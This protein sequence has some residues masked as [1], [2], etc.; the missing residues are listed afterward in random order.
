ML[1]REDEPL[2]RYKAAQGDPDAQEVVAQWD[3]EDGAQEVPFYMHDGSEVKSINDIASIMGIDPLAAAYYVME[4]KDAPADLL[5]EAKSVR[6]VRTPAGAAWYDQPIGSV[7]VRDPPITRLRRLIDR[8]GGTINPAPKMGK[9]TEIP[10]KDG[11]TLRYWKV[12]A[13]NDPRTILYNVELGSL[14]RGRLHELAVIIPTRADENVVSVMHEIQ[15]NYIQSK[16]ELVDRLTDAPGVQLWD[17]TLI[18]QRDWDVIDKTMVSNGIPVAGTSGHNPDQVTV[19]TVNSVLDVYR[20]KYDGNLNQVLGAIALSSEDVEAIRFA[21]KGEKIESGY[22]AF[23]SPVGA[24]SP[25]HHGPVSKIVLSNRY[26]GEDSPNA[27]DINAEYSAILKADIG[28][29][30]NSVD[31]GGL[32][33]RLNVD[34]ITAYQ[35]AVLHH[36]I[37]H[38]II[39]AM[40][41]TD[42]DWYEN[43]SPK[44]KEILR[45]STEAML[46][47]ATQL[48]DEQTGGFARVDTIRNLS[49]YGRINL[50]EHL[51]EAWSSYMLDKNPTKYVMVLGSIM[52]KALTVVLRG[53]GNQR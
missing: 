7:I 18:D 32:A 39:N 10:E 49:D 14:D 20:K 48:Y 6:H 15:D 28:S 5:I 40:T 27:P 36:E 29:G 17:R 35:M 38:A 19:A 46:A 16:P 13:Q 33:K 23:T 31:I 41:R 52:D 34:Q 21:A 53:S 3:M 8:M 26:F 11:V 44:D 25:I 45:L 24:Q 51:A 37:G 43:L 12:P 1:Q 22:A 50:K 42:T 2:M 4:S 9:P 47:L 30:H